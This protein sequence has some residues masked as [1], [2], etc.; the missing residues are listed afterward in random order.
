MIKPKTNTKTGH[1]VG[2]V[3]LLNGNCVVKLFCLAIKIIK[4]MQKL[5]SNQNHVLVNDLK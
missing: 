2:A 3:L 4:I 5:I 1:F